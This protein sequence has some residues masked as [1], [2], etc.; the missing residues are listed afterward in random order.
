MMVE[1]TPGRPCTHA[2]A[3]AALVVEDEG[4]VRLGSNERGVEG[5]A[6]DKERYAGGDDWRDTEASDQA[7]G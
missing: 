1:V 5:Q 6:G 7:A 3:T 4:G 2:R